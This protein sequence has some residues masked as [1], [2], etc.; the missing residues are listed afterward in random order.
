MALPKQVQE[1]VDAANGLAAGLKGEQPEIETPQAPEPQ[2]TAEPSPQPEPPK[3]AEDPKWEQRYKSLQGKYNHEI[4]AYSEQIRNLT[5][6]NQDLAAR[7]A[8]M[9]EHLQATT[10]TAQPAKGVSQADIDQYGEDLVGFVQ[11]QAQVIAQEMAAPLA[12]ENEQLKAQ[13][14]RMGQNVGETARQQFFVAL[15]T[16]VR[17]WRQLNTDIDFNYWLDEVDPLSGYARRAYL[18]Q[19]VNNNDAMRAGVIFKSYLDAHK[20]ADPVPPPPPP[21]VQRESLETQVSPGK[22]A[23]AQQ[24]GAQTQSEGKIWKRSEIKTYHDDVARGYYNSRPQVKQATDIDI[25][26]ALQAGRVVDG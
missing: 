1:Q 22:R 8:A 17:E 12:Q 14:A 6:Q 24:S 19:A 21:P 23:G 2:V 4:A 11:R 5:H 15:D 10:T 26:K 13:L 7:M 18:N 3:P 25:F 9:E 16:Q 20:P